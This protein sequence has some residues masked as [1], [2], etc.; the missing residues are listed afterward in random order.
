MAVQL[1]R[2]AV[3]STSAV[4]WA[5]T[6]LVGAGKKKS[7]AASIPPVEALITGGVKGGDIR[8]SP[9]DQLP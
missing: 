2:R 1:T 5:T 7:A 8:H 9:D 4:A 3:L 6:G